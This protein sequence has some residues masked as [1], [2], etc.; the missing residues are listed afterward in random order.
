MGDRLITRSNDKMKRLRKLV[1]NSGFRNL[2]DAFV[3]EGPNAVEAL[4]RS[5]FDVDALFWGSD[6]K[7]SH[8]V[9]VA[10]ADSRG[11]VTF[12]VTPGVLESLLDMSNPQPLVAVVRM[13]KVKPPDYSSSLPILVLDEVR[14]PGNAGTMIRSAHA[15]GVRDLVFLNGSVDPYNPKVVRASAGSLFFVTC[16]VDVSTAQLIDQVKRG[17]Y[18]LYS[19]AA[20]NDD[21]YKVSTSIFTQ[22]DLSKNVALVIGNEATGITSD[23]LSASNRILSIPIADSLESLNASM[24]ATILLFESWRQRGWSQDNKV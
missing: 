21:V 7:D 3:V 19:T 18:D 23:L 17:G 6:L 24:A 14:D 8:K 20:Q 22:V 1:H 15:T 10:V 2:E 4:L 5:D 9:L 12:E 16:H 11:I 13:P